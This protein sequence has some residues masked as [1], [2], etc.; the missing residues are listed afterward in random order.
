VK[1]TARDGLGLF[2]VG[3]I[4]CAVCCAG[5]LITLF[6]GIGLAGLV[7]SGFIG[8]GGVVIALGAIAAMVI[9]RRRQASC[10]VPDPEPVPVILEA[11]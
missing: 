1:R 10:A 8:F 11:R 2:G 9:L 3:A 6:G 7:S 4:A 5:P